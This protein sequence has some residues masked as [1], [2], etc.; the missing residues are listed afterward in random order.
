[1]D[2]RSRLSAL[3]AWAALFFLVL[4]FETPSVRWGL[5]PALMALGVFNAGLYRFFW[6]QSGPGF[7]VGAAV[8]L[9]KSWRYER[10]TVRIA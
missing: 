3:S 5:L 6:R 4:G 10:P 7:A 1:V 9:D 8:T 2:A